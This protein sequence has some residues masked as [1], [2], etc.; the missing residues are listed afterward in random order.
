MPRVERAAVFT[1]GRRDRVE[2][3]LGRLRAVADA[4]GVTLAD[5]GATDVDL[6]VVLGGDGTM[7][8]AL[9]R[10]LGTGVPVFGVNFGRV[11][12]LTSAPGEE[13]EDGVRRAFAGD[14]EVVELATLEVRLEDGWRTAVNDVVVASARLG[15]MVELGFAIGGEEL[16]TQ[17]CDGLIC[18]TPS[19]STAYNLSNGGPVL[20]WGLDAMVLTFVA[21]HSL[22]ARPL[23]VGREGDLVVENRTGDVAAKVLVD[24]QPVTDLTPGSRVS[25]R[26]GR[27]S[28]LLATLPERTFFRRYRDTFGPG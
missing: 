27:E 18:A 15:R 12:F 16:G 9:T 21:P 23:V 28:S 6:A 20:V 5:D 7:L 4:A 2:G 25:M 14:Y 10:F 1:H 19:G 3:A 24:G 26:L 11:G 22:H 17:P 8:R 13:L